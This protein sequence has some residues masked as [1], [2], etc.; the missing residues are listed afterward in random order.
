MLLMPPGFQR[1]DRVVSGIVLRVSPAVS[2]ILHGSSARWSGR[3]GSRMTLARLPGSVPR[4][5]RRHQKI[6]RCRC[7]TAMPLNRLAGRGCGRGCASPGRRYATGDISPLRA[8]Y[9]PQGRP[10]AP[11]IA[12]YGPSME[13]SRMETSS[14]GIP[15]RPGIPFAQCGHRSGDATACPTAIAGNRAAG[16]VAMTIK[17]G[18]WI[19]ITYGVG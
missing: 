1:S 19:M 9:R 12:F 3:I 5:S 16:D 13:R 10:I 7:A 6:C 18:N 17:E 4:A 11:T 14:C 8:K 2:S 15:S